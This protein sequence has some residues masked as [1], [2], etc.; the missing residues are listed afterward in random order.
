MAG[1][2]FMVLG[3]L[4]GQIRAWRRCIQGRI[5]QDVA[6]RGWNSVADRHRSG[7]IVSY[8]VGPMNRTILYIIAAA[9]VV[10]AVLLVMNNSE[11]PQVA[12]TEIETAVEEVASEAAVEVESA[13]E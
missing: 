11:D 2:P 6:H 12:T 13:A 8:R 4:G 9:A 3:V 7:E 10:A 5:R 1:L